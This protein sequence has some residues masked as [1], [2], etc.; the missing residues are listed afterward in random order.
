MCFLRRD[1][2]LNVSTK[3]FD[4]N[5][6]MN[7]IRHDNKCIQIY[8]REMLWNFLPASL[9]DPSDFIEVYLFALYLSKNALMPM[10]AEFN[11]ITPRLRIIIHLQPRRFYSICVFV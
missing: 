6:P 9:C 11:E 2:Q 7:M 10:R 4:Y 5:N 3:I 8:A 1:V